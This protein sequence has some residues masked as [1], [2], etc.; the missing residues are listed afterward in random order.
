MNL[1]INFRSAK[2]YFRFFIQFFIQ[3]YLMFKNINEAKIHCKIYL[4]NSSQ[5]K[6]DM[7]IIFAIQQR[8]LVIWK[9]NIAKQN[10]NY[11]N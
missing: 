9:K 4:G 3:F 11:A 2:F 10:K 1:N 5:K 6:N 7:K 8:F